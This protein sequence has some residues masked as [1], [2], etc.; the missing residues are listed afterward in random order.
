MNRIFNT[1]QLRREAAVDT[2]V[3][4][5]FIQQERRSPNVSRSDT[6]AKACLST[7]WKAGPLKPFYGKR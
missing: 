7:H 3:E 1:V 6:E 4:I 5:S 2:E